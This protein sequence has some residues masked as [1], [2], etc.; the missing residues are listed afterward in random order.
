MN[1][2]PP[3]TY[4]QMINGEILVGRYDAVTGRL[5]KAVAIML[6]QS[7]QGIQVGFAPAALPIA[8]PNAKDFV[9]LDINKTAISYSVNLEEKTASAQMKR[10]RQEYLNNVSP[11]H[12]GG[13]GIAL[14]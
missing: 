11:I 9:T 13:A 10:L 14:S 5:N 2:L 7:Q 12:I 3:V 4:I 6:H 1:N 8:D